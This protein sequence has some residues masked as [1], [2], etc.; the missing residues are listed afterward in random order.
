MIEYRVYMEGMDS[1]KIKD[2]AK[3]QK[4]YVSAR[5]VPSKRNP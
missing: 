5:S 4:G 2:S 1:G 3:R